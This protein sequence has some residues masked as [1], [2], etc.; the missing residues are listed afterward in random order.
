M[1][2]C[3]RTSLQPSHNNPERRFVHRIPL[4]GAPVESMKILV[5][6]FSSAGDIILTSLFVR[7]LRKGFPDAEIHYITKSEFAPL[8]EHSPY[9]DR[10][11]RIEQGWGL[12]DLAGL[13]SDLIRE[14][15]GD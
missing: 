9:I 8:V 12:R 11:I 3:R 14:N 5:I 13:K 6:R 7:A 1:P 10:V 15:D 4:S 2:V